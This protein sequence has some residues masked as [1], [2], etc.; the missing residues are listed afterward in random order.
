MSLPTLVVGVVGVSQ[1]GNDRTGNPF[2]RGLILR[3][4]ARYAD[5]DQI[6]ACIKHQVFYGAVRF[7][8]VLRLSWSGVLFLNSFVVRYHRCLKL[9]CGSVS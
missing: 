6:G 1:L 5:D 4:F 3:W 7:S 8:S 9:V 2:F